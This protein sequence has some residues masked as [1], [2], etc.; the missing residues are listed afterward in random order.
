MQRFL[1]RDMDPS[2]PPQTYEVI[3][4]NFEIKPA[5]CT[6]KSALHSS[7]DDYA[8]LSSTK[9]GGQKADIHQ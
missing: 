9:S 5:N 1:W 6:A 7:A 4:N 3:V 8:P 2:K